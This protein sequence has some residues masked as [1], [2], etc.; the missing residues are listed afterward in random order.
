MTSTFAA[1]LRTIA[2]NSTSE[3]DLRARRDAHA[4]SLIFDRS[5]A[6]KQDWETIYQICVEGFQEL[7]LLDDRLYEFEHNL[8][9][10]QSKTQDREQLS[11]PQ[12]EAL[13]LVLDRCLSLLGS[14]VVLR[15]GLKAVEWLVRR[16]RVHVYNTDFLLATFLP[17]H[18]TSVFRI[19]LS[20]IPIDKLVNGWKFLAPYHREAAIVPRHTVIY[21]A[22]HN[23]VFFS[24]FNDY[25]LNACQEGAAHSQLLRFWGSVVVEAITGRLS[26]VRNGRKEVQRQRTEDALM[27]ILPLLNEAFEIKDIPELTLTCFTIVLVLAGS[28]DVEDHVIDSLMKSIAPFVADEAS[29]SRSALAC[30]AILV[31]KKTD[32]RVPRDVLDIFIG[33][34]DLGWRL[35]ELLKLVPLASLFEAMISSGLSGLKE[36]NVHKRVQF[37]ER[38]FDTAEDH[39]ASSTKSRLIA[40]LL[41]KLSSTDAAFPPE[42]TCWTRL[43]RLLQTLASSSKFSASLPQAISLAGRSQ[44][45]VEDLLQQTIQHSERPLI[46]HTPMELDLPDDESMQSSEGAEAMLASLPSET[47]E[48]S[49]LIVGNRSLLFDRLAR[50]FALCHKDR[51]LLERFEQLPLWH[52]QEG[53]NSNLHTSF[54]LRV[55]LGPFPPA[56][57]SASL[58]IFSEVIEKGLLD[59]SEALIPYITV[60]LSDNSQPVRRAAVACTVT[61]HKVVSKEGSSDQDPV[62]TVYDAF[63]M[64]NVKPLLSTQ[65][66]KILAQAY[67]PYLEE[68][69]LD[70]SY[71]RRVLQTAFDRHD[72]TPSAK[73]GDVELKKSMKH[74]LYD[75]LTGCALGCPLLRV[76]IGI[77]DLLVDV[78]KLGT[79]STSKTLL[80]ILEA[81]AP[82]KEDDAADAASSEGL[83]LDQIDAVMVRLVNARDKEAVEHI[84][85]ML[86]ED[87][88]QPRTALVNAFFDRIAAIWKD[89]HNDSQISAALRLFDM[90]FSRVTVQ[91]AGSRRVLHTVNLS[92]EILAAILDHSFAGLAEM[93]RDVP[94]RKRR[95]VSHG[96]ESIPTDLAIEL[97]ISEARLTL[98]LELVEDSKPQNHPQ[99]LGG[100]FEMLIILRRLKDKGTSESPYL[101]NLCLSSI[102]AIVDNARLSQRPTIDFSSIRTDLVTDCVRS[103]EN[104]QVQST[105]LLL[106]SSLASLAPDRILHSIMPIFT[107]MGKSILSKDD[108]RSIYVTNR[109]I[110]EIIPPL[111]ATLKKQDAKKLVHSTSSLLSSF[112][113]AYDHVPQYRRAAFYQRLLSRLGA[114]DF[115]F[116][117]IALLASRRHPEDMSSFFASLMADLP[118]STQLLTFRKLIGLSIDIFSEDPHDAVPLL[119]ISRTSSN[120]KGEQEA[121]ILLEVASKLL[122]PKSLKTQVQRL[123]KS[124]EAENKTFWA[125]FKVCI[126]RIL[127]MLRSQKSDGH[128][129]LTPS[130]RKCLSSLLELPS[131]ADLLKLM[132]NL[133]HDMVQSGEGG[134]RELQPLALRVLATQLQH[135]APSSRDT[136]TQAEAINFLPTLQ[137]IIRTTNDEAFR[138]AAIACL[139]RIIEVYGRKKPEDVISASSALIASDSGL[140]SQNERTRI[141]SLLCLAS[142]TEVLKEGAVPIVVQAL[143]KVLHLLKSFLTPRQGPGNSTTREEGRTGVELHDAGFTLLSS[144][145]THTPYMIDDESVAEILALSYRS[146]IAGP[147]EAAS[148]KEARLEMLSLMA[149]RLD[150]GVVVSSLNSAWKLT[151]VASFS[152][153]KLK[154]D[155]EAIAEY[156]DMLSQAIERNKKSTV[157]G[158]ADEISAFILKVLDLRRL[159]QDKRD[160]RADQAARVASDVE[161]VEK[162]LH[163]L[164]IVFIYKLND[165]TF[166]PIFEGWVEWA[167]KT[168]PLEASSSTKGD[169]QMARQ[170]SFY[171]F[172]THFFATL[173]S[174]VTSYASYLLPSVNDV[175]QSAANNS[176]PATKSTS[177]SA[178]ADRNA[179]GHNLDLSSDSGLELY[180]STLSLITTIAT[181]DADGFFTSPSHFQPLA[182][183]LVGQFGLLASSPHRS[184]SSIPKSNKHR[185]KSKPSPSSL[186]TTVLDS[187]MACIISLATAVQDV[188]SHHHALNHQ[189]CQLRRSP[190]A[191]VRLASIRAQIALTQSQHVGDEWL[192]N[193]VLGGGQSAAA[194]AEAGA[195]G[196]AVGGAGETMIYVNE[197]LEDDDEN[198]EDSVRDWVVMVRERVG[199][200]VF[201]F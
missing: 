142:T 90:S 71:I 133:L 67:L 28:A 112:V 26:Q 155:G 162:R 199:E 121:L 130:T 171:L 110:D 141:M 29:I 160:N 132:P 66:A 149:Q 125:E 89:M 27:K 8:F 188:P 64:R 135:S 156:L 187:V 168:S 56:H 39:F 117:V 42:S 119:D 151:V 170:T 41:R 40:I 172:A 4:D 87:K 85:T 118:A 60:L 111:V 11:K 184:K 138:H 186:H 185:H 164:G 9:S 126:T 196:V 144:F 88:V 17:Y 182:D 109:A 189:L 124:D 98:A 194:A 55:A 63:G 157:V 72:R 22:T 201:E 175:L 79:S 10:A 174:I 77:L 21:S 169:L 101:L 61:I 191:G 12:N 143:P 127:S 50:T 49:F 154:I 38:I 46:E 122:E 165:T 65:A 45:E 48:S 158:T 120:E 30:L 99:L 15:P 177:N 32:M 197:M 200:D 190:F 183:L 140:D 58:Q 131:L 159:S 192:Q 180:K 86:V 152:G 34:D 178:D 137:H 36:K 179:G 33:T 114:D 20:I 51:R 44:S 81:W 173:K 104:P 93:Q 102:L 7:C 31:T 78:H 136:R 16:F 145:V 153:D 176:V 1:Q 129:N 139:D 195:G 161:N 134:Q 83:V 24:F 19:I 52:K 113:T 69:I 116:A 167:T 70:P 59:H 25:T 37:V 84:L 76:K 14:K 147:D 82:L 94:P 181:H 92:T 53:K 75:L 97:D 95:R 193:V 74:A 3:L 18:E 80:P 106:S 103:S 23:E 148:R 35:S 91:A 73:A 13:G 107:F 6:V 123:S 100:L 62:Q 150:L 128:S 166:R 96:R 2:A 198:V 54:L 5:V 57:R 115:A 43:V 108:E 105:A 68:C 146:C 47:I 163:E